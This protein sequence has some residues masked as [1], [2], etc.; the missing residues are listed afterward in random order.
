MDQQVILSMYGKYYLDMGVG[1]YYGNF[2]GSYT[3]WLDFLNES[4]P[5]MIKGL[6]K[7]ENVYGAEVA[8]WSEINNQYT[9]HLKVWV[10]SCV[11]ADLIWS[12]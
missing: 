10:R 6:K 12:K 11:F 2:Y 7:S 5:T 8:L 3:T 1:N 9:H 4:L